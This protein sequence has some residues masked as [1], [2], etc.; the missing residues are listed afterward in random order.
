MPRGT[1]QQPTAITFLKVEGDTMSN[2][3]EVIDLKGF[4]R[5]E[6]GRPAEAASRND[7]SRLR[8]KR[9][10]LLAGLGATV[11]LHGLAGGGYWMLVASNY[12]STDN[13]YVGASV[14]QINSQVSGPIAEVR[15]EDTQLVHKGDILA[16]VDPSDAKLALARAEAD[17]QHTLQRVGQYYAQRAVAAATVQARIADVD[18]T[19]EDYTRR[20]NLVDSG[21]VSRLDVSTART[22]AMA[23]DANLTAARETLT[24]QEALT[25]DFTVDDHPETV[26]ARAARDKAQ[27]DLDRTVIRAPID[28]IVAQRKVQIGQSVQP[29]QSLMTVTPLADVYVD[30]NFKEGQLAHVKV[31]QPVKL[32]ADLYGGGVTY[33]GRIAG[34]GGGTGSAF[35]VIPAQNATGNW[36]K[37]VQRV[38]VRIALDRDE[39]ASHPLRVGGSISAYPGEACPRT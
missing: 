16:V 34:L 9:M 29:G 6:G 5:T 37:V 19:S 12:V 8:K 33:H 4:D 20:K 28:G 21:A 1:L 2:A 32:E 11:A 22:N 17:Y 7:T 31:G 30:A 35:A 10:Q 25:K 26:A 23:A 27:L 15:A 38:P 13:A 36:I 18:R 24:A 14:A 39:V 3:A